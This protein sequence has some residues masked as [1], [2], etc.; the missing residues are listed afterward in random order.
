[1]A[2]SLSFSTATRAL[3]LKICINTT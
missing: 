3:Q 2:W 1:V